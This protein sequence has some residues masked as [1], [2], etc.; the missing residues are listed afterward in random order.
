[1]EGIVDLPFPARAFPFRGLF[2]LTV[3]GGDFFPPAV[4]RASL[5]PRP[6]FDPLPTFPVAAPEVQIGFF[7]RPSPSGVWNFRFVNP[8]KSFFSLESRRAFREDR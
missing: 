3:G 5:Y 2:Y 4:R 7:G 6:L 8:Q 1:M